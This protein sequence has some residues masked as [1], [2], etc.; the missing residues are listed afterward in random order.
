MNN[1]LDELVYDD[2]YEERESFYITEKPS[3]NYTDDLMFKFRKN[4]YSKV[5]IFK[6]E[7][8]SELDFETYDVDYWFYEMSLVSDFKSDL[9]V[10]KDGRRIQ[11]F[12]IDCLL[13]YVNRDINPYNTLA[14]TLFLAVIDNFELNQLEEDKFELFSI[15]AN[16]YM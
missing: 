4:L 14:Y 10:S 11:E 6:P 1:F 5:R 9:I 16:K 8:L 3:R 7:S 15:K 12:S 13:D 2:D